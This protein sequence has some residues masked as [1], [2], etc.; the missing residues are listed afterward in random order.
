M[1]ELII[2]EEGVQKIWEVLSKV[3]SGLALPAI[4]VLRTL[5]A[6]EPKTKK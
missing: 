5:K 4:D 2:T 6:H 3:Q 1:K